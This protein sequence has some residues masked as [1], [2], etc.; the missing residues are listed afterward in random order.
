MPCWLGMPWSF[1]GTSEL[2]GDGSVACGYLVSTL[3]RDANFQLNRYK[4]AQQ[5]SEQIVTSLVAEEHVSRRSRESLSDFCER[6]RNLGEGLYLVGLDCHVGFLSVRGDSLRFLHSSYLSPAQVV[7]E[8]AERSAAL[9]ATQYRVTGRL[10][11]DTGR[12]AAWLRGE[13]VEI[14]LTFPE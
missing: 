4:L 5:A 8:P 12:M 1:H 2:P 7:A 9:A 6:M 14:R 13:P 10:T 3:L 11:A